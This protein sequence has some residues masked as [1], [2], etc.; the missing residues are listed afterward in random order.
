ML[1][2]IEQ[3]IKMEIKRDKYCVVCEKRLIGVQEKY[4]SSECLKIFK[5]NKIR[6]TRGTGG[7]HHSLVCEVCGY[8][9]VL[10]RKRVDEVIS[11][12]A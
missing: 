5:R 6:E 2:E 3:L 10:G 11:K 7:C 9:P 12:F 4:C 1:V 8:R